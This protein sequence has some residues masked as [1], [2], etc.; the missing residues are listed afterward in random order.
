MGA[1]ALGGA[2]SDFASDNF[3]HKDVD[4]INGGGIEIRQYGDGAIASNHVPKDTPK[5]GQEFKKNSLFYAN[6]N[7]KLWYIPAIMSCWLN[8]FDI[9]PNNLLDYVVTLLFFIHYFI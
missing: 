6:R 8:F 4:F 7:L 3:E 2:M 5:W 9:H 1:G